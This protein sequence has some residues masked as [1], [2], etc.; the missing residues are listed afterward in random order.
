MEQKV[1]EL[2]TWGMIADL[3]KVLSVAGAGHHQR[4]GGRMQQSHYFPANRGN[5]GVSALTFLVGDYAQ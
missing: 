2:E 3:H 1:G 4:Y 5:N